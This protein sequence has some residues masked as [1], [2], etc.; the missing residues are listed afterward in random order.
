MSRYTAARTSL[1]TAAI[2]V[3]FTLIFTSLMSLTYRM[4]RPAIEASELAERMRLINEVLPPERYDNALLEDYVTIGPAPEL[5]LSRDS[6]VYRARLEDAPS[7]LILEAVAPDGYGGRIEL[8]VAVSL[9][10]RISGVRVTAH[11]ETPGLGDYIDPRKDRERDNPWILQFDEVSFAQVP[12]ERWRVRRDGGAFD[13]RIGATIS[14]SAV[15]RATG[16]ALEYAIRHRDAL[17]DAETGER[18]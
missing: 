4:T 5:G 15:T 10:G 8:A 16:R 18:L 2:M 14:A 6:R 12:A 11:S 13:Y 1:R 17:F 9:D 7:A 3:V